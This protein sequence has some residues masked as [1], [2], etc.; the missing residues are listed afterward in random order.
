MKSKKGLS[1]FLAFLMAFSLLS[2]AYAASAEAPGKEE[3]AAESAAASETARKAAFAQA[4]KEQNIPEMIKNMTV[5]EK[6]AQ[7]FMMDFRSQEDEDEVKGLEELPESLSELLRKYRFGA[8]ILFAPNFRSTEQV[9]QLTKDMQE[10]ASSDSGLPLLI[11]TDQEG[12]IVYRMGQGTSM[13]GNMAIAAAGN[14][15]DAEKM[16]EIIG[17]ELSAVGINTNLAPVADVNS[18]AGNPIIGVRS[19][20]D[21]AATVSRFAAAEI[22]GLSESGVITCAKHFPGHGNTDVDSHTGLPMIDKTLEELKT[23]ELVPFRKAIEAG[24]DMIM[25]AHILYPQIDDTT[26]F[27]KKLETEVNRPATLSEKII[28][29]LL[30]EDMHFSGVVLSDDLAMNGISDQFDTAQAAA[31]VLKAGVDMICLTQFGRYKEAETGQRIDSLI[32]SIKEELLSEEEDSLSMERL[33]DAVK[34]ILTLKKN[35][36]LLKYD[37][38]ER[39]VQA[40]LDTLRCEEHISFE[41]QAAARGITVIKNNNILPYRADENS[42]VLMLCP[43]ADVNP[44]AAPMLMGWNRAKAA[45]LIPEGAEV[46]FYVFSAEDHELEGELKDAVDEADT[47]I[48]CSKIGGSKDAMAYRDWMS[49]CPREITDYCAQNGKKSIVLSVSNPYDVQ[50]YPEADAIAA[51]YGYIGSH[52]DPEKILA[53]S[54]T[55]MGEAAGPNVIAGLEVIL[56]VFGASGK[57]PVAIPRFDEETGLFDSSDIVYPRGYGLTYSA[58]LPEEELPQDKAA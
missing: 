27:S 21:D 53:G 35:K 45:G 40:A 49:A 39:T 50:L 3:N 18:N 6:I 7:T 26:V 15:D 56:G 14:T 41:R 23:T 5:E 1:V 30:K 46:N 55:D 29:G 54:I 2:S 33:D 38:E 13:P 25:T 51:A 57:L 42:R 48:L 16:G 28:T 44:L 4:L 52:A 9:F 22:K 10:A 37:P 58:L 34:R 36:G 32:V 47:V 31:E 43:K 20:S 24:V 11:A 12:G 8:V 17:R 19:F